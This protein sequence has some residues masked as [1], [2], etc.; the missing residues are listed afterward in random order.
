MSGKFV[1]LFFFF[2]VLE[3]AVLLKKKIV[4]GVKIVVAESVSQ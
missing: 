3:V 1:S 4:A 2:I